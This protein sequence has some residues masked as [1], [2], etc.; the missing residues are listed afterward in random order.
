[1]F[2]EVTLGAAEKIA[3]RLKI[4]KAISFGCCRG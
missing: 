3:A 4:P 2:D 1:M